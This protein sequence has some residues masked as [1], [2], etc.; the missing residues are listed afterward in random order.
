[1]GVAIINAA[2]DTQITPLGN[3]FSMLGKTVFA[4]F[5]KQ[6]AEQKTLIDSSVQYPFEA[7]EKGF[8]NIVLNGTAESALRRFAMQIVDGGE[9]PTHLTAQKPTSTTPLADLREAL[10]SYFSWAK[11]SGDAADLLAICSKEEMPEFIVNT[12]ISIQKIIE[13]PEAT[14]LSVDEDDAETLPEGEAFTV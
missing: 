14:D 9:W 13:P 3:Y 7:Q 1:M 8:E 5:D 10:R 11:G 12:L 6:G 4:V 2:T